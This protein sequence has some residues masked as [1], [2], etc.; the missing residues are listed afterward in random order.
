MASSKVDGINLSK[1]ENKLTG[2]VYRD[3]KLL[4]F[5]EPIL[6]FAITSKQK[7]H[8][9]LAAT[10]NMD[11]VKDMISSDFL[12]GMS[13]QPYYRYIRV[14]TMMMRRESIFSLPESCNA[15][16]AGSK[17][18]GNSHLDDKARY[19]VTREELLILI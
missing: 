15:N 14:S 4:D 17:R 6:N 11:V 19:T 5:I 3:S 12:T 16:D 2:I 1:L 8:L 7:Y 10:R 13:S 9:K 18:L